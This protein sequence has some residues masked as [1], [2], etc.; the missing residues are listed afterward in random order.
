MLM[1]EAEPTTVLPSQPPEQNP[2]EEG[3]ENDERLQRLHPGR[4]SDEEGRLILCSFAS[5][6]NFVH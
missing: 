6:G 1:V 5:S 4:G 2:D 3:E